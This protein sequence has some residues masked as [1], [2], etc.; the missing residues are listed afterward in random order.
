VE[1]HPPPARLLVLDGHDHAV[2]RHGGHRERALDLPGHRVQG[3]VTAR[4]ELLRQP[5]EQPRAS[6][7][8]RAG[9]QDPAGLAVLWLSEQ[10][11]LSPGVLHHG[12]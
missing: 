9:P 10:A 7:A 4:G 3:V 12:L 2:R 1:L 5:G 11:Q 6:R 8:G